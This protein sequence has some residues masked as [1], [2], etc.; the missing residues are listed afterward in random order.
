MIRPLIL[1]ISLCEEEISETNSTGIIFDWAKNY[2][3]K[4]TDE[5]KKLPTI[6]RDI[7]K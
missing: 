6:K 4:Q 5:Q 3:N 1:Q 2:E 7:K